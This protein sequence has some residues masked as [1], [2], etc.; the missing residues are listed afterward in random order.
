MRAHMHLSSKSGEFRNRPIFTIHAQNG[1]ERAV[2][3]ALG[4]L[5]M[6]E[7]PAI[8]RLREFKGEKYDWIQPFYIE[9]MID[10]QT[11]D[12]IQKNRTG[13]EK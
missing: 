3:T 13:D 5:N 2:I 12:A 8:I 9:V 10:N 7:I 1:E 4:R 11:L 6:G